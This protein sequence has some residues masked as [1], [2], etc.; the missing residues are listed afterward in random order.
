MIIFLYGPNDF[1]AKQKIND[2]RLG[3]LQKVTDSEH[4][5]NTLDGSNLKLDEIAKTINTGSLFARKR[6][7]IIENLFSNKTTDI[8]KSFSKFLKDSNLTDSEDVLIIYEPRIIIDKKG[9]ILKSA[10]SKTFSKDTA[11]NV[12][13]KKLFEFLKNQKF[14]QEFKAL[15]ALE[16]TVWI[17]REVINSQA[18]IAPAAANL[19]A[20]LCDNEPW[21]INNEVQKLIHFK[22]TGNPTSEITLNDVKQLV[23]DNFTE[24]IFLLTDALGAKNKNLA[25]KTLEE[26]YSSGSEPDYILM[27]LNRHFK[28]LVQIRDGLDQKMMPATI[29]EELKLNNYVFK[30]SLEQTHNFNLPELKKL[31]N[32]LIELDYKNKT[33]QGD[34][35]TGLQLLLSG[36]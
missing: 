35:K 9:K 7:T 36:L 31:L 17:K 23:A 11:L 13:E 1:L 21:K 3:F 27:M 16:A 20:T 4:S 18:S 6:L 32:G 33:G 15:N 2:L 19:I 14:S 25:L 22:T 28:I 8:L 5:I 12:E 24:N 30:K 10:S 29:S 34:L 26:Q